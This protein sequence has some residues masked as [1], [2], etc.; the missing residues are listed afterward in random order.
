MKINYIVASFVVLA[1]FVAACT[2]YSNRV[3]P[4]SFTIQFK[5][6]DDTAAGGYTNLWN[7]VST[8]RDGK[9]YSANE[10]S[11]VDI[12]GAIKGIY[13]YTCLFTEISGWSCKITKCI[14]R[15]GDRGSPRTE[16]N[17]DECPFDVAHPR[18]NLTIKEIEDKIASGEFKTGSD[19]SP[20][21]S[22]CYEI[23]S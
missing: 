20:H 6:S 22:T 19:C 13:S 7:A 3:L 5:L 1:V 14:A 18:S 8:Y 23:L 15:E 9:L 11:Y 16:Y 17:P 10:S 12:V 4:N 2:I 21:F